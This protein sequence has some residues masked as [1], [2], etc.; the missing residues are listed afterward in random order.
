MKFTVNAGALAAALKPIGQVVNAKSVLQ[1]LTNCMITAQEDA[2]ELMGT[3]LEQQ[4]IIRITEGI[5][6]EET[7]QALV[8]AAKLRAVAT[9]IPA[10]AELACKTKTSNDDNFALRKLEVKFGRSRYQ[11]DA[12]HVDDYPAYVSPETGDLVSFTMLKSELLGMLGEVEYAIAKQDVRHYLNGVFVEIKD[13]VLSM[14]AT[15]GHRMAVSTMPAPM[16][17]PVPLEAI[18]AGN[19]IR[20]LRGLPLP[21]NF[22]LGFY[23]NM[24]SLD[25]EN[26]KYT[27]KLIDGRYPDYRRVIPD[28]F[29]Y[30]N[31]MVS[32]RALA[33]TVTRLGSASEEIVKGMKKLTLL[34]QPGEMTLSVG[35][36]GEERV[37]A[38][39][40]V[41][42][43][44][45]IAL[46][47]DYL[48]DVLKT[49][50]NENVVVSIC[51]AEKAMTVKGKD[52]A[53][54][55]IMPVRI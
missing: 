45:E 10:S 11:F 24:I 32:T 28:G 31:V 53:L 4:L 13:S 25:S 41:S 6:I 5:K 44:L 15:D 43:T 51:D 49:I 30:Y 55:V 22:Q 20:V 3:D 7:G 9:A 35:D 17:A 47:L 29:G 26:L 16:A 48:A 33:E 38:V 1:I 52:D 8:N 19:S 40:N 18:V 36:A 46:N 34:V 23:P 54:A 12:A 2:L 27:A 14:V 42:D 50:E 37:E 39:S 21:V